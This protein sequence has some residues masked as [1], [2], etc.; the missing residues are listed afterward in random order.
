M[1]KVLVTGATGFIA[2]HLILALLDK[3]YE[4]RGTARSAT[5]AERLNQILSDYAGR[6]IEVELVAADLTSDEGW[7]EAMDGI[8]FVQH[9]ASP[10]PAAQPAH[11]DELIIPARDGALRVLRA[12]K[13]AGVPRVVL[14]SSVAA[15]DN[16]WGKTGPD[17]FDES[18]WTQLD[19]PG[20]VGFYAQS[21]TIAERA[22]WDYVEGEGQGLEL[23]VINPAGVMGPVMSEDVSTSISMI[24]QP[25]R[26]AFPA[27]P[28]LHQGIVDVRDIAAAHIAAMEKPEAAG[29]RFI[30]SAETL[31]LKEVG[32]ILLEAYPDR[33]LPKGEIP[34]WL[35]RIMALFNPVARFTVPN[36]D[37][38]RHYNNA[39]AREVLGITFISAK[40]AIL[41]SA[42]SAIK[43]GLVD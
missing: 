3:G 10:F 12:A 43:L 29:Q 20:Q 17:Q 1:A 4:V 19:G 5:K 28:H 26:K 2:S 21:K 7:S 30:M 41:A 8:D 6:P 31:W 23:A 15:V 35:M 27:Y 39:K 22:A 38:Q 13:A 40:A 24:L 9:V 25:L 33:D 11:A 32:D 37:R 42:R 16:G 34:S 18:H 14:T 36:L